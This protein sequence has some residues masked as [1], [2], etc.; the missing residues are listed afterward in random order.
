MLVVGQPNEIWGKIVVAILTP[1]GAFDEAQVRAGLAQTLSSYKHP[2]RF[3]LVNA[4]PRHE[5]GKADYRTASAI[6]AEALAVG[7]S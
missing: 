5:S 6:A 3:I 2:K 4:V 1:D 7:T